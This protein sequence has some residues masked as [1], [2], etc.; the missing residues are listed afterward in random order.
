MSAW[1]LIIPFLRPVEALLLD[2]GVS[3]VMV[4]PG[5]RVFIERDGR[6][7]EVPDV[8]LC[9]EQLR[10]AVK[11]I[12]R[13]LGADVSEEQPVLDAR[14]PDGSRVA[15]ILPPVSVGGITL[16]IRKFTAQHFSLQDL[17]TCGTLPQEVADLLTTRVRRR[18]NILIS[19]ATSTGKTTLLN[20]LADA[21]PEADRIVLIEDTAEVRI[22]KPNLV[23]L[24]ARREQ[25][26]MPAVTIRDLI[27]ATLRL[28]PD[29]IVVGEIR[30]PE[31][32]DWLQ[33]LNTG[34]AGAISTIHANTAAQ[35]LQ[36]FTSCVLQSGI[37]IPYKAIKSHAGGLIDLLVHI[38]RQDGR[39]MVTQVLE[40]RAYD[41]DS[42]SYDFHTL[43]CHESADQHKKEQ[44]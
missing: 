3:E 28:R 5:P 42:D 22:E 27:R 2:P 34:H 30:G 20:I 12:A 38:E 31:A 43:Y 18:N 10:P 24:E 7:E 16:A 1:S 9:E 25:N 40:V 11:H 6:L 36:R 4:N 15:A 17:V 37:E 21:I 26:G 41:P 44:A 35:A 19:G 39:R 13:L 8:R 23:R 14:L 32:Y 33:A 29:R